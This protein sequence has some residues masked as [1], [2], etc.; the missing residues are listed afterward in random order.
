MFSQRRRSSFVAALAF[1]SAAGLAHAEDAGQ[2]PVV[3]VLESRGLSITQEFKVDGGL[4]AF[5]GVANNQPVAVYVT[6]DGNAII[7]IRVGPDGK[8]LDEAALETSAAK[9]IGDKEWSQLAASPWVLDGNAKAPRIVY[10]F[11]DANCPYCHRFWEAARPWV[12]SGKVQLREILVGIIKE[13]SPAKAAAILGAADSS[14]ALVE[15]EKKYGHG[16]ITPAKSIP[17]DVSKTLAGN[18]KLMLSMG[19]EG[20][21]GIVVLDN[22]GLVR[23]YNGMPQKSS[24]GEVLGPR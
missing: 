17:A 11:T 12:D 9:P 4:R 2:P 21:P 3:K 19:F 23:K 13:D 5:A 22:H 16:G 14:A 20:T 15:N 1:L 7:G 8:P 18:L 10:M 24:L 6:G